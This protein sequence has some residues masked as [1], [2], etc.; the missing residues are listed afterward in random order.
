V[1]SR[2]HDKYIFDEDEIEQECYLI[3]SCFIASEQIHLLQR[4]SSN[5]GIKRFILQEQYLIKKLLIS[6]AIK[7]RMIDDLMK[8]H[9]KAGYICFLKNKVGVIE[10]GNNK[11]DLTIREACNKII[12]A[13][14]IEFNFKYGQHGSKKIRYLAPEII[15][16][17]KKGKTSWEATVKIL[18]LVNLALELCIVY[19]ES[20]AVS[21]YS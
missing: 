2:K 4:K 9:K 19:D 12:H 13:N 5:W 14:K 3:A 6:L 16:H 7:L 15:L 10:E 1:K 21:G 18:Q 17:G 8:S 11:N 20:W